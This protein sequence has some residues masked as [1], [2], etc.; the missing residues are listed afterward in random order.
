M[1]KRKLTTLLTAIAVSA[2]AALSVPTATLIA[3][4]P[5]EAGKSSA[6][7][8]S[9]K[10]YIVRLAELPVDRLQRQH[11]GLSG[12]EAGQGPEDRP[13]LVQGRQLHGLPERASRRGA[14]RGGR[15]QE[16][17]TATATSFNGFAAELT[18]AQADKLRRCRACCR[19]RRTSCVELDTSST[20][21]FLGLDAP[22]GLWDQL[23]GAGSAGEDI[24]IGVVDSRHLAG[25]PELLRPHRQQRQRHQGR[26]A[27][28]PADPGLARQ[29][30]PGRGV[31]RVATATRS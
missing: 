5:S 12:D 26:Q 16:G 15:R 9:N 31:Q 24:I 30:R 21:T 23:G 29:V 13:D 4:P 19:S 28:L 27:G 3:A 20:P 18:E 25:E 11:Q 8:A 7:A 10:F 2:A 14:R 1:S 17:S 22:G 6:K